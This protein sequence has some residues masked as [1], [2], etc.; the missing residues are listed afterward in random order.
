MEIDY[1]ALILSGIPA[2]L[3]MA[4]HVFSLAFAANPWPF[5]GVGALLVASAMVPAKKTRRRRRG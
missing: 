4:A 3:E 5:F 2:G 1:F